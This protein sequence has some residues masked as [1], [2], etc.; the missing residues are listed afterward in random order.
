LLVGTARYLSP[1]QAAGEDV[2][3]ASDGYSLG[4]VLLE[5]LTGEKP[6]QGNVVETT[7]ARLTRPPE[8]PA[9]LGPVAQ[10]L[11]QMTARE[12]AERPTMV[13]VASRLRSLAEPDQAGLPGPAA[14]PR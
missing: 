4:L 8:I 3:V 9:S 6:Y 13:E 12:P 5:C 7:V 14:Q 2:G 11:C 1:E 10:L